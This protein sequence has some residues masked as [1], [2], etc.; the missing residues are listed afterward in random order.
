MHFCSA[1]W[2]LLVTTFLAALSFPRWGTPEE[3][4]RIELFLCDQGF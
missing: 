2:C 3:R 4:A 1:A